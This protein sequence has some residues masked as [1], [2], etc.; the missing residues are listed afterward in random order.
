MLYLKKKSLTLSMFRFLLHYWWWFE[1]SFSYKILNPPWSISELT[2]LKGKDHIFILKDKNAYIFKN[3]GIF[4]TGWPF[5]SLVH[6]K[7]H[8]DQLNSFLLKNFCLQF[9]WSGWNKKKLWKINRKL[10]PSPSGEKIIFERW[11]KLW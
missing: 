10:P 1:K 4:L 6:E 7:G 2:F 5:W 11:G 9:K 8:T 3:K